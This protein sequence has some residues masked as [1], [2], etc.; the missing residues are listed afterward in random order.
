MGISTPCSGRDFGQAKIHGKHKT[1]RTNDRLSC[2]SYQPT[3]VP[4]AKQ[5]YIA[6]GNFHINV[7]IFF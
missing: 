4:N 2:L 3:Q 5:T 6:R 1:I 7:V